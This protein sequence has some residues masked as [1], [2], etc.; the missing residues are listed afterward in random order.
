MKKSGFTLIELLI[1][2]AIVGILAAI[3]IPS[4]LEYVRRADRADAKAVLLED[5]QFLERNF[6]VA[7]AY[8]TDSAGANIALP[9]LV[10]PKSGTTKYNIGFQS[11]TL[12]QT[13][14]TLEAVPTG[15]MTGD[16]CGTF[17]VSN[18]GVKTVTGSLGV[19]GCWNK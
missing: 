4:Y 1:V 17:R 9:F 3:A 14:Y 12:T 7:N 2:I 11:G 15:P 8:N 16:A 5:A 19:A 18:T 10:S 13:T 6:T